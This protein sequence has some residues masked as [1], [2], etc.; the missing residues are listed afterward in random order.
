[1]ADRY[2][3]DRFMPDKAIDVIDEAAAKV[4][5]KAG[6][7]PSKVRDYVKQ[8]KNL[9]E[10]ME[11]AVVAEEYERAAL[12]KTRISQLN[13]KLEESREEHEKKTPGHGVNITKNG[14]KV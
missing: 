12:Y 6:H 3:S 14:T 11:E 7:K 13:E 4:R 1:M 5:V 10:K 9:N 2:V 8:L